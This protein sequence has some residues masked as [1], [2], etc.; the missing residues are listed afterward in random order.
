[1][2]AKLIVGL[3]AFNEGSVLPI[4]L[5]K[6]ESLRA[7][8]NDPLHIIVVDDGSTDDTAAILREYAA[9]IPDMRV[10]T[11]S[12]NRGL[13]EAMNTLFDHIATHYDYDDILVTLDADNTHN[14]S[15]IPYLIAKLRQDELDMVVASRYADGG[16]ELGLAWYRKLFSRGARWFFK[17]FFPIANVN[18]YSSGFRCYQVGFLLK[19]MTYYNGRMITSSGFECMAE[20]M[21]RF[22]QMGVR[23]GEFPLILE[24]HL[25]ESKS[26]MKIWRTVIGYF[27]LL[28]KVKFDKKWSKEHAL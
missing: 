28:K 25:K 11:H 4:L 2:K 13:G 22:S 17:L 18:D 3:P 7:R 16:K 23:A 10:L 24:Y 20:I 19:A 6:L 12:N 21:A 14:P 26:K 15:I 5:L 1:M 9:I 27:R 8:L